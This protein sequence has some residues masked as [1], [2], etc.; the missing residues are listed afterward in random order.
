MQ[1]HIMWHTGSPYWYNIVL[2]TQTH[3]DQMM[4]SGAVVSLVHQVSGL[5]LSLNKWATV[6]SQTTHRWF[7]NVGLF[8]VG[9]T[10]KRTYFYEGQVSL[11]LNSSKISLQGHVASSVII[12]LLCATEW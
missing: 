8:P 5:R 11:T 7:N 9:V 12:N 1:S 4:R 6:W 10:K 3:T 2:A